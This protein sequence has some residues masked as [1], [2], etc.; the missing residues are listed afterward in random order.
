MNKEQQQAQAQLEAELEQV[1]FSLQEQVLSRAFPKSRGER[2]RALWN[3]ELQLP[4][5]PLGLAA[6][7]LLSLAVMSS[8][9]RTGPGMK[10]ADR[11]RELVHVAGNIYWKDEYERAVALLENNR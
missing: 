6:A 9:P 3:K 4:V 11:S 7:V 5:I 2:L 1:H 10:T 8:L